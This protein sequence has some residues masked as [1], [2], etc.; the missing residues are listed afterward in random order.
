VS[1]HLPP[2]DPL[3]LLDWKR[4]VFGLY[5]KVRSSEDPAVAWRRW[6]EG[7][8]TLLMEHEQSPLPAQDGARLRLAYFD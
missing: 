7:R 1:E 2:G 5:A 3:T 6:R 8:D 4:R